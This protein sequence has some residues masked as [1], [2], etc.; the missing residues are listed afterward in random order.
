MSTLS[1]LN[2]TCLKIIDLEKMYLKKMRLTRA[3]VIYIERDREFEI[4]GKRECTFY[5][6][7]TGKRTLNAQKLCCYHWN[8]SEALI[9]TCLKKCSKDI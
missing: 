5:F 2:N 9:L 3:C 4:E 6:L 1:E 8:C 7:S